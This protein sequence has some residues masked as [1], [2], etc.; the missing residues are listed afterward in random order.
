MARE[1]F[2]ETTSYLAEYMELELFAEDELIRLTHE[3]E[4]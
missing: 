1:F 3:E 2:E 4:V